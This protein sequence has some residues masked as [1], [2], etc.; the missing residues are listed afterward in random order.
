MKFVLD[1][2]ES[3]IAVCLCEETD[4]PQPSY[5]FALS[6]HPVLA[7]FPEGMVFEATLL[8]EHHATD[9]VAKPDETQE[10]LARATSRLH[11]LAARTKK[12]KES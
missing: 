7:T 11:A 8:D 1:R 9:I 6:E 12:K 4:A 10:R 3:H 5:N 2:I